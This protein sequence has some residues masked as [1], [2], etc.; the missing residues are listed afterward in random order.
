MDFLGVI[1]RYATRGGEGVGRT[2]ESAGSLT[3]EKARASPAALDFVR[4]RKA[5]CV[6]CP[7]VGSL[8]SAVQPSASAVCASNR[9][10]PQQSAPCPRELVLSISG[11]ETAA[12]ACGARAMPAEGGCSRPSRRAHVVHCALAQ[13]ER[14]G[15]SYKIAGW[16][17]L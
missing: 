5:G 14:R 9:V 3:T 6:M 8:Q 2:Q 16:G 13:E 11:G 12:C 15:K 10:P 17:G 7:A 4:M 1:I